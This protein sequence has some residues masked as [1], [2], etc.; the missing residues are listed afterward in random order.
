[1]CNFQYY[2]I[3]YYFLLPKTFYFINM[4][5]MIEYLS[6]IMSNL[7]SFINIKFKE[8]TL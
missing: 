5:T 6:K 1:M 4:E 3:T 2:L 7:Y 8:K